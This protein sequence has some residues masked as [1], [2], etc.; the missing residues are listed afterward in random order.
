MLPLSALG[1]DE[2]A[3]TSTLCVTAGSGRRTSLRAYLNA[4]GYEYNDN[5][6][7]ADRSRMVLAVCTV[8]AAGFML[9]LSLFAVANVFHTISA[10]LTLRRRDFGVLTSLGMQRGQLRRM[11]L[12]ECLLC[13]GRALLTGI[14]LSLAAAWLIARLLGP[15]VVYPLRWILAGAIV[16]VVIV[17]LS[18]L[19]ALAGLRRLSP[20]EAIFGEYGAE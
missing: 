18:M 8:C 7:N 20:M 6:E 1:A 3:A 14:L 12:T 2:G 4:N 13:G 9:L 10:N 11:V 16:D 17:L 15:G 19:Y 5:T